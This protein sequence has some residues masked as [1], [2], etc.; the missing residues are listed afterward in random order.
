MQKLVGTWEGTEQFGV[1]TIESIYERRPVQLQHNLKDVVQ[2][3]KEQGNVIVYKFKVHSED[4]TSGEEPNHK[5]K[6]NGNIIAQFGNN[7]QHKM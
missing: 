2:P 1:A 5:D 3:T 4:Q 7:P 6:N